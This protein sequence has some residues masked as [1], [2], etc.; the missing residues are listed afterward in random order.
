MR[1]LLGH[2]RVSLSCMSLHCL[3][4]SSLRKQVFR[5][6][7]IVCS[8]V[9]Y[10][11][12]EIFLIVYWLLFQVFLGMICVFCNLVLWAANG[13]SLWDGEAQLLRPWWGFVFPE[14]EAICQWNLFFFTP[15]SLLGEHFTAVPT[16]CNCVGAH[17]ASINNGQFYRLLWLRLCSFRFFLCSSDGSVLSS[18][19]RINNTTL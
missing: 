19:R 8:L 11:V 7:L 13:F 14:D 5:V 3:I 1:L 10:M 2:N 16:S 9:Y 17:C 18:F 12:S 4:C 15:L 6:L